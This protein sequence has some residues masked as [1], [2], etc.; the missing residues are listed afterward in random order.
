VEEDD[1]MVEVAMPSGMIVF[2]LE[3]LE[4]AHRAAIDSGCGVAEQRCMHAGALLL[5]SAMDAACV[6]A[7]AA[8]VS[9]SELN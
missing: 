5:R 8:G 9:A 2:L 4:V 7:T 6:R 3:V 1:T